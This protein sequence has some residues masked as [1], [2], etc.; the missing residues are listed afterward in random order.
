[1][2]PDFTRECF[3]QALADFGQR[4]RTLGRSHRPAS[5]VDP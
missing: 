4:V 5:K 1:M 3:E 2:W